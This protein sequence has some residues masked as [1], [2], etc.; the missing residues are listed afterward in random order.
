MEATIKVHQLNLIC[1]K[2]EALEVSAFNNLQHCMLFLLIMRFFFH[3]IVKEKLI[4]IIVCAY[5]QCSDVWMCVLAQ[6]KCIACRSVT[7]LLKFLFDQGWTGPHL[8]VLIKL[9]SITMVTS[10]CFHYN[11]PIA[12][13]LTKSNVWCSSCTGWAFR[14]NSQHQQWIFLC[15]VLLLSLKQAH[16]DNW[17]GDSLLTHSRYL[18]GF[19]TTEHSTVYITCWTLALHGSLVVGLQQQ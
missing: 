5:V 4:L 9:T 12:I 10:V 19:F 8:C 15:S 13:T 11:E 1:T 16:K 7:T 6:V 2:P 17:V 3:W 14:V 18:L